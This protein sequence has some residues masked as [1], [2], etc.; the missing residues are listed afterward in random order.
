MGSDLTNK[1]A[2]ILV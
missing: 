1:E 2:T